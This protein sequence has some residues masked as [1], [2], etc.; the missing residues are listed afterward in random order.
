MT[1]SG[2]C[3]QLERSQ[4]PVKQLFRNEQ[5]KDLSSTRTNSLSLL[6]SR[7][8]NQESSKRNGRHGSF[9]TAVP[10]VTEKF[11]CTGSQLQKNQKHAS[12]GCQNSWMPVK[13]ESGYDESRTDSPDDPLRL[14]CG[15]AFPGIRIIWRRPA[16]FSRCRPPPTCPLVFHHFPVDPKEYGQQPG[17]R[18]N[19]NL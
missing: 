10:P 16:D 12:A 15:R 6:N 14:S 4:L 8:R 13:Q 19:G 9:S 17:W 3:A 1:N 7:R 18:S 11:C 2:N 5:M